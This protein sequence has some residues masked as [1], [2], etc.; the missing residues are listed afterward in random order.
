MENK[1][2][3]K[4]EVKDIEKYKH[5]PVRKMK[6]SNNAEV[7]GF[8]N[9]DVKA[10]RIDVLFPAG[11][12]FQNKAFQSALTNAL[13]R[14]GSDK[15]IEEKL[16]YYGIFIKHRIEDYWS[17]FSF[18]F[19]VM[20]LEKTMEIIKELLFEPV[21]E[22]SNFRFIKNRTMENL[23]KSLQ[24]TDFTAHIHF[25]NLLWG[26]DHPLGML[27]DENRLNELTVSD[28]KEFYNKQYLDL[29]KIIISGYYPSDIDKSLNKYF[30]TRDIPGSDH[31]IPFPSDIKEEKERHIHLKNKSQ[32][33][34]KWGFKSINPGHEDY[35]KFRIMNT[36]F[37]GYFGSRL[38]QNI[39]EDKA[40]TYGVFSSVQPSAAGTSLSLSTD[41]G[42]EYFEDTIIQI[43]KEI[44]RLKKEPPAGDELRLI[45][46]YMSG[47]LLSVFDGAFKHAGVYRYMLEMGLD[48]DYYSDYLKTI[49][50]ITSEDIAETAKKY[51]KFEN[52]RKV[53]AGEFL[54]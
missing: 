53:S 23:I 16:D 1:I 36:V 42:K 8:Y 7:F 12:V 31:H 30:G 22:K 51:L 37:G 2:I 48:F 11:R 32:L 21:I 41:V 45:K 14:E 35:F 3:Q 47:E 4:P 13:L 54:K 44:E 43:E 28:I 19:P 24:R 9:G 5:L 18:N 46:N 6:L 17:V 33:T 50:F 29:F 15:K 39:R 40:Y 34:V 49:K 10:T 27:P 20:Y 26:N 52:F 38:M 25:K